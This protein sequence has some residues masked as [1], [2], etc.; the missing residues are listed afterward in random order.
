MGRFLFD[1]EVPPR[2]IAQEPIQPRD[3]SRLLVISRARQTLEHRRFSDLPELL[4]PGDVLVL[5][6]TR[7]LNA[8][9]L[10]HRAASGGRW[11][12]LFL[13]VRAD[14]TWEIMGQT[15]GR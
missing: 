7:V 12:G 10:G 6:D 11:E 15:R 1:F 9:L 4:R 5:N 14:G 2:L 13:G 8:R 3:H